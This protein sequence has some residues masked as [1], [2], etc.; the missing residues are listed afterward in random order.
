[1]RE[2]LTGFANLPTPYGKFKAAAYRDRKGGEH[3]VVMK[4]EARGKSGVLTRIHSE[5][6][7]GNVFESRR[8]DCYSQLHYAMRRMSKEHCGLILYLRQ[9]G[10]GHGLT[11]KLRAYVLQDQGLDTVE[12][13]QKLGLPLDTREYSVAAQILKT[14]RVKSVRLLTNNPRKI[15]GLKNAR[16]KVERKSLPWMADTYNRRYLEAKKRKMGHL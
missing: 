11:D 6:L 3:L 9:E 14:L 1:M 5:C 7:T 15:T 4:G 16:I 8:C 12:A 13:D 2:L 10:R